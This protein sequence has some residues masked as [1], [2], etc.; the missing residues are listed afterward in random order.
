V[1]EE[2]YQKT[3]KKSV[4]SAADASS[5]PRAMM[6]VMGDTSVTGTAVRSSW[7]TIELAGRTPFHLDIATF[8]TNLLKK[9][10]ILAS[11]FLLRCLGI[12]SRVHQTS[13]KKCHQS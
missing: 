5:N 4:I 7:R 9:W 6:V 12:K 1:R 13:S 8:D 11:I 2:N 3:V 10:F